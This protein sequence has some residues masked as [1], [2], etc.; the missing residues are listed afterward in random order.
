[1]VHFQRELSNTFNIKNTDFYY[2]SVHLSK[3]KLHKYLETNRPILVL[4]W[5]QPPQ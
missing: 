2:D 1:M 5:N 4:V 3:E